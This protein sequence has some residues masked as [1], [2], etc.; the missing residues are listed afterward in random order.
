MAE[1]LVDHF[2]TIADGIGG[3]STQ[4]KSMDDFKDYPSIQRIKQKS[5][6]CIETRMRVIPNYLRGLI[7]QR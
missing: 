7:S 1:V 5:G 3:N 6:R 4:L 2:A